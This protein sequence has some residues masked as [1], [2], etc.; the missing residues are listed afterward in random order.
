MIER[1][2]ENCKYT[3]EDPTGLHCINCTH[4]ALDNWQCMTRYEKIKNMSVDELADFLTSFSITTHLHGA[5]TNN[6]KNWLNEPAEE[7]EDEE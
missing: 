3:Y 5:V 6:I 1:S 7:M 2:C 4:N